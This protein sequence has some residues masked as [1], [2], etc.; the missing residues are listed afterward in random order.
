[1]EEERILQDNTSGQ[2]SPREGGD[3]IAWLKA[4]NT[5]RYDVMMNTIIDGVK[6]WEDSVYRV[7][8]LNNMINKNNYYLEPFTLIIDD[9]EE[10]FVIS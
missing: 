8:V 10:S 2:A 6:I 9:W 7:K 5:Q 4:F 3:E 1:M